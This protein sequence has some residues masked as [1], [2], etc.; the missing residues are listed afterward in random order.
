MSPLSWLRSHAIPVV[1]CLAGLAALY[2]MLRMVALDAELALLIT[3]AVLLFF[4]AAVV[5]DLAHDYGFWRSMRRVA[6]SEG[7]DALIEADAVERPDSPYAQVAAEALETVSRAANDEVARI[8]QREVE[9]REFVEAWVHEVKTPLAAADLIVE[10]ARAVAL[11]RGVEDGVEPAVASD[12]AVP[13]AIEL[14]R[15]LSRELSRIDSYVEQALFFARATA[16][17]RD[18]LVRACDLRRLVGDA[19]KSRAHAL[20]DAGVAVEMEGLEREVFADPKWMGFVLG[21]LIDNAIKY[22]RASAVAPAPTGASLPA[23][24]DAAD[25]TAEPDE[26]P[27]LLFK[28]QARDEG[29]ATERVVLTVRDNGCGISAADIGRIFDKGFTGENGRTHAKST[30]IGLYLVRQLC[31]KMGLSVQ[32]S[33]VPGAWTAIDITFPTNRMHLFE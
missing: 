5:L 21:Q 16:V 29:R 18:Y 32:A 33:S 27:H 8:R 11:A 28:A 30:G 4:I 9:H 6:Q 10:N 1:V 26:R 2:V 17:D 22:R 19:V 12:V 24:P 20:I 14:A 23:E 31:E 15:S 7:P 25:S 13:D 3:L